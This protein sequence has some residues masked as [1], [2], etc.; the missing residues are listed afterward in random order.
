M[1]GSESVFGIRIRI[2]EA[3][4]NGSNTDPDPQHCSSLDTRSNCWISTPCTN[5]S[6]VITGFQNK[7]QATEYLVF[8]YKTF[9]YY[10]LNYIPVL[11]TEKYFYKN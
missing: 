4:E 9:I 3:P 1:C 11:L 6:Y 5:K 2:Q 7:V 8:T 10:I